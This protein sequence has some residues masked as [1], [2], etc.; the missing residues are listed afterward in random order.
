METRETTVTESASL[1]LDPTSGGQNT[2]HHMKKQQIKITLK[3]IGIYILIDAVTAPFALVDGRHVGDGANLSDLTGIPEI[4]WV[5]IWL[6][7]GL[8]GILYLWHSR[9]VSYD[10]IKDPN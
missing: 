3:F 9:K 1:I 8:A 5:F 2:K 6:L 10:T 4:V 7:V